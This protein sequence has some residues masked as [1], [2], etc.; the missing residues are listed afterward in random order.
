MELREFSVFIS[1]YIC[2]IDQFYFS[3]FMEVGPHLQPFNLP[4]GVGFWSD[5]SLVSHKKV[6]LFRPIVKNIQ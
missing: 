3:Y 5:L 1:I 6:Q 4:D 2:I